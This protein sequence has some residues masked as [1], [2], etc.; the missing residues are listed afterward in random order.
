VYAL[1]VKKIVLIVGGLIF[2]ALLSVFIVGG[3]SVM[4]FSRLSKIAL[5]DLLVR[6]VDYNELGAFDALPGL[7]VTICNYGKAVADSSFS[8]NFEANNSYSYYFDDPLL[9]G[10]CS[11][12]KVGYYA[13]MGVD[14]SGQDAHVVIEVDSYN[15]VKEIDESNNSANFSMTVPTCGNN[16]CEDGETQAQCPYD[17]EIECSGSNCGEDVY[18]RCGCDES[19]GMIGN[20]GLINETCDSCSQFEGLFE[21]YA[22]MQTVV[23]ECLVDYFNFEPP[24]VPYLIFYYPNPL[25]AEECVDPQGCDFA[26]IHAAGFN[27][28]ILQKSF[29]KIVGTGADYPT[30]VEHLVS[31]A[32]E[33]THYFVGHMLHGVPNWF[34]EALAYN[35]EKRLTCGLDAMLVEEGLAYEY[36]ESKI[37]SL[38]KHELDYKQI[39]SGEMDVPSGAHANGS[40]FLVGLREEFGCEEDCIREIVAELREYEEAMCLAGECGIDPLSGW[41]A[42]NIDNNIIYKVVTNVVGSEPDKLFDVLDLSY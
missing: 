36:V 26:G 1:F 24:R 39:M 18:V 23:Y 32:H 20:I 28:G 40:L 38:F 11:N 31:D 4:G 17:C 8:I 33:I 27:W 37:G 22:K 41:A 25:M 14:S 13:L 21:P 29:S 19:E 12:F 34:N 6:N 16:V 42:G 15:E 7:E 30:E 35:S 5:P 10:E 3:D 2:I 9:V